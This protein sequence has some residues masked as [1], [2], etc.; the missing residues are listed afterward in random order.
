[1]K[2]EQECKIGKSYTNYVEKVNKKQTK[3]HKNLKTTQKNTHGAKMRNK[4]YYNKHRKS[5]DEKT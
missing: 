4:I 1:M 2:I 3:K 5:T